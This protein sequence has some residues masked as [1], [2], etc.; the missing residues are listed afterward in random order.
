MVFTKD[1]LAY[2][3]D[4]TELA[5]TKCDNCGLEFMGFVITRLSSSMSV[6]AKLNRCVLAE[7]V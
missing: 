1:G 7:A 6:G 4:P 5:D 3:Q 2:P